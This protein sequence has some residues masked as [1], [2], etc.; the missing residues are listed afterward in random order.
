MCFLERMS[1]VNE[2][3]IMNDSSTRVVEGVDW[4][5]SDPSRPSRFVT[6]TTWRKQVQNGVDDLMLA[7][8]SVLSKKIDNMHRK[9]AKVPICVVQ[10]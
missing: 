9:V 7:V 6:I 3:A 8:R 2:A 1:D 5:R 4:K 10:R